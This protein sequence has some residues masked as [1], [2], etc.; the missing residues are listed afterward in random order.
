MEKRLGRGLGSLL[1]ATSP[2]NPAEIEI[3]RI[4]PNPHQPRREFEESALRELSD[5]LRRHGMLQP[6]VVRRVG[7]DFQLI[8]GE[9]RW[10]AA[11]MAGL[12]Q[13]PAMIREDVSEDQMLELALVENLQRQDLDP[14]ERAEGFRSLMTRLGLTQDQVAEKVG[15]KRA[16]VANHLRMLD[17]PEPVKDALGADLI[18]LG[19]AKA[20]AGISSTQEML[21]LLEEAVRKSLSV[22][23]V[24]D[25][26]RAIESSAKLIDRQAPA[27]KVK[28][29]W[30]QTLSRRLSDELGT[31][32]AVRNGRNFQGRIVIEYFSR[33]ELDRLVDRLAP[34]EVL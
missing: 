30:T 34:R 1:G 15:L 29:A 11:Q 6:V 28:D 22:R 3:R 10:R 33:E 21:R 31:K 20:L 27:A 12:T 25:R 19:H 2:E 5:S 24:E 16:T 14:I 7:D 8:S 17:L 9:R 18:Q 13:V 4:R 26:V 23:E 32:V